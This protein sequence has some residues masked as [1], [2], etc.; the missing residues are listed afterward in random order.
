MIVML[1]N[2]FVKEKL[3]SKFIFLFN[4][5]NLFNDVFYKIYFLMPYQGPK[6]RTKFFNICFLEEMVM[7]IYIKTTSILEKLY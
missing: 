6:A 3:P 2:S 7:V 5:D 1:E 4:V